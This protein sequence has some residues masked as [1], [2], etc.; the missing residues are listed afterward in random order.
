MDITGKIVKILP[1]QMG[2]G[3]N[4]EW[5]KQEFVIQQD[6]PYA[7]NACFTIWNNKVDLDGFEEKQKVK[8]SFTPES[9][10]YNNRWYTDLVAWRIVTED[11]ENE[12]PNADSDIP[13]LK[14][15]DDPVSEDTTTDDLP[16]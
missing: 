16:F 15:H 14:E 12:T 11:D 6:G 7:K 5:K 9:R 8:V 4:G 1:P 10:E 2:H 13:L 3:K